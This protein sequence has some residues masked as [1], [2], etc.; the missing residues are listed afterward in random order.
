MEGKQMKKIY[1]D[2]GRR[3]SLLRYIRGYTREELAERA[4][5]SERFL[6][7]IE[8]GK[9]GFSARVLFGLSKALDVS[10]DYLLNAEDENAAM[11]YLTEFETE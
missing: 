9:K 10:C 2:A 6:F 11:Q 1:R 4:K 3:I 7:E 8:R 5:I